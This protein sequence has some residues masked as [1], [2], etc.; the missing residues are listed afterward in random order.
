MSY[1]LKI[2]YGN[3][4]ENLLGARIKIGNMFGTDTRALSDKKYSRYFNI[5]HQG[6]YLSNIGDQ[7]YAM[8]QAIAGFAKKNNVKIDVYNPNVLEN[9]R[10]LDRIEERQAKSFHPNTLALVVSGKNS[11]KTETSIIDI[12]P[13][14]I[15]SKESRSFYIVD[16]PGEDTQLARVSI[17]STQDTFLRHVFRL[18]ENMTK[19]VK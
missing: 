19:T 6:T 12:E 3:I 5:H 4:C 8:R 18:I 13:S 16:V 9:P 2:N 7:L 17:S 14:K 11:N 15:F 10:Y 1:N